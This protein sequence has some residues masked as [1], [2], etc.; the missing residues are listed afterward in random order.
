MVVGV[1]PELTCLDREQ[2][3]GGALPR[4]RLKTILASD[5]H[6]SSILARFSLL[7]SQ[8]N[9]KPTQQKQK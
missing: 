7:S 9:L 2:R 4:E 1:D 8:G 3:K 5:K 6:V